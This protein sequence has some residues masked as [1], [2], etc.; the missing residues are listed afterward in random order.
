MVSL[1]TSRHGHVVSHEST[2]VSSEDL[3]AGSCCR[4]TVANS[5]FYLNK[6]GRHQLRALTEGA[7]FGRPGCIGLDSEYSRLIK[8]CTIPS[9]L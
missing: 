6:Q 8:L 3:E 4:L 1:S 9:I 2:A 5:T 7:R